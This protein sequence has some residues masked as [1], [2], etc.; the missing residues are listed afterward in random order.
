MSGII[1]M[2]AGGGGM[3]GSGGGH[4]DTQTVTT[5]SAGSSGAFDRE[6]GFIASV[7]GS[8]T[9]GTSNLYAGTPIDELYWFENNGGTPFYRLTITGA[10]NSGW[11]TITIGSTVLARASGTY[12]SGTWTWNTTDGVGVQ[13]F[14]SAGSVK[15]VYFD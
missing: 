6:R 2:F 15:T 4:L 10:A 8:I 12:S 11:A 9:D 14:G 7:I 5:G 3:G 13:A 1:A